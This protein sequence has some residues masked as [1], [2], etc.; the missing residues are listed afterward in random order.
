MS[1]FTHPIISQTRRNERATATVFEDPRSKALLDR[2]KQIAPSDANALIIGETGTGKELVARQ[3]HD[4]SYRA[5]GP[6]IAVNCGALTESLAESELFGHEK[7]LLPE[8]SI[9]VSAG[10]RQHIMAPYF[11]M[12][13]A[14]CRYRCR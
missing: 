5:K 6:F 1:I 8:R 10:L 12:K 7:A 13:L 14:I 11:W 9:S 4:L 3:I 2:I